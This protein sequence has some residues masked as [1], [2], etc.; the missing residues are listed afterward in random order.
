MSGDAG[1]MRRSHP[2]AL[3]DDGPTGAFRRGARRSRAAQS[4]AARRRNPSAARA[5]S[6]SGSGEQRRAGSGVGHA[7]QC[8]R[9]S[10][11]CA[12]SASAHRIG[13]T[14]AA[15]LRKNKQKA[16]GVRSDTPRDQLH[17]YT[18]T[19]R[20]TTTALEMSR[21]HHPDAWLADDKL[22]R[23]RRVRD[24]ER[25]ISTCVT[26]PETRPRDESKTGFRFGAHSAR[27]RAKKVGLEIQRK[28][29]CFKKNKPVPD[30]R[31]CAHANDRAARKEAAARR[32]ASRGGS[33]EGAG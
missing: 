20:S 21:D 33:K 22:R 1:S 28:Y 3:H 7:A 29:F 12:S 26:E 23:S 11:R 2:L 24:G 13:S 10:L 30:G 14:D 18:N 4:S 16:K 19:R 9:H 27:S 32:S 17:P 5:S 25:L 6:T 31:E 15:P 8:R